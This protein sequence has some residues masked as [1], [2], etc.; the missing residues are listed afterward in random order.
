MLTVAHKTCYYSVLSGTIIIG[1]GAHAHASGNVAVVA[2]PGRKIM[3]DAPFRVGTPM[4][5]CSPPRMR[6]FRLRRIVRVATRYSVAIPV[7]KFPNGDAKVST[8]D[9]RYMI[10]QSR[11]STTKK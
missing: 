1:T 4:N 2:Q 8:H 9:R 11:P 3:T 10:R 5:S 7:S 6:Y